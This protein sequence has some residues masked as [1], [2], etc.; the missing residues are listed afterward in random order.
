MGCDD[1]VRP[2]CLTDTMLFTD[3]TRFHQQS[4][5][6]S[7]KRHFLIFVCDDGMSGSYG[8]RIQGITNVTVICYSYNRIFLIQI[9]NPFEINI[10]LYPNSIKWNYTVYLNTAR[11]TKYFELMDNSSLDKTGHHFLKNFLIHNY[12]AY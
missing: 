3:Y 12:N 4:L 7:H 2:Q 6:Q 5:V 9:K 10:L 1:C 8:N 11:N